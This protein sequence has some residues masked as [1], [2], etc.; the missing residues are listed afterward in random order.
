VETKNVSEQKASDQTQVPDDK[1]L[2]HPI[3]IVGSGMGRV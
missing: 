1:L 2:G 3:V